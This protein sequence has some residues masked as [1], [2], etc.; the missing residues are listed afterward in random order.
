[1]LEEL[2][3]I[4]DEN[5]RCEF[6]TDLAAIRNDP[7]S[8]LVLALRADFYDKF[9]ES[10]EIWGGISQIDLRPLRG[11]NLRSAIERPALVNDVYFERELV[12]RLL[13]EA[14]EP[15]ALPLLQETLFQLWRRRR[16]R[17]LTLDDYHMPGEGGRSRLAV[18]VEQHAAD[19]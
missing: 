13:A 6:L 18:A 7:R 16:R 5:D 19:V 11:E 17:L 12:A 1:Q 4:A 15:G 14:D 8:A 2:F 3:T 9:L 10:P